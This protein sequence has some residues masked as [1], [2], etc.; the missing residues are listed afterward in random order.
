[1]SELRHSNFELSGQTESTPIPNFRMPRPTCRW[2]KASDGALVMV[3]SL[4]DTT[5]PAL[6]VT[7]GTDANDKQQSKKAMNR[8]NALVER[9]AIAL[10]L[11]VSGYL[12]ILSFVSDYTNFP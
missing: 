11:G 3:W 7:G 8:A 9:A 12:T 5:R 6:R 4:A 2:Q 1:M 10:L